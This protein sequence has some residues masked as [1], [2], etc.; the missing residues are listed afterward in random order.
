MYGDISKRIHERKKYDAGV[1][2]A[3]KNNVY[4][5]YLKDISL[6]G[7]FVNTSSVN[8]FYPGD[9]VSITIPYE[10]KKKYL[11]RMGLIKWMNNEGFALEFNL[12]RQYL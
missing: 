11:K 8:Q 2:I 7:A 5:G 12:A 9:S 10:N 4:S 1:T 3:H 6:G